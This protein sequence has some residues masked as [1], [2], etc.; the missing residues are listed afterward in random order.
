MSETHTDTLTL[1]G[2][3]V[4]KTRRFLVIVCRGEDELH[5]DEI[6]P[7]AER[8]RNRF[9]NRVLQTVYP[10]QGADDWPEAIRADL[11]Q[12]LLGIARVPPG[13]AEPAAPPQPLEDVREKRLAEMPRDVVRAARALLDSPNLVDRV[14]RDIEVMGVAGERELALTLYL[15]G[16]SVQL[17]HPLSAIIKGASSS[18]KS[19]TIRRVGELF[20]EE[21]VMWASSLTTNA[22][23]YMPA[24]SLHHRLVIAG[25]RSRVEDDERAEAT[26]ALR[27]MISDGEI[28][29]HAT[30]KTAGELKTVHLRQQGPIAYIEA[31]TLSDVFDEDANRCLLLQTDERHEQTARILAATARAAAGQIPPDAESVRQ[32]HHAIQRMLPRCEVVIPFAEQI[33]RHFKADQVE[34]RRNFPHLLRLVEASCL[35]HFRQ[36]TRD[37]RERLVATPD[38]YRLAARLARGPLYSAAGGVSNAARCFLDRIDGHFSTAEV[39]TAQAEAG[40]KAKPR[41][42]YGWMKELNKAGLVEPTEPHRGRVPAKWRLTG[43]SPEDAAGVVPPVELIFPAPDGA[44][45]HTSGK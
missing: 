22:L 33:A 34:A 2:S 29:K 15:I 27:D 26:R 39:T 3:A 13:C 35:L 43:R 40:E 16:V 20:P 18:G 25:E 19:H 41:T 6:N 37:E 4:P 32:V 1:R 30:V 42:V 14:S 11:H 12:Q 45:M 9:I 44:D 24:G 8:D 21:V 38:D 31:T 5:R 28:N 17:P 7:N 36:R 10:D 23:Y